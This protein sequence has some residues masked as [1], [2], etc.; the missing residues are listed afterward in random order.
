MTNGATKGGGGDS[1]EKHDDEEDE[2]H[3]GSTA[4][5]LSVTMFKNNNFALDLDRGS[6][7]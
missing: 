6:G 4:D 7:G 2:G 1:G 3:S 5:L